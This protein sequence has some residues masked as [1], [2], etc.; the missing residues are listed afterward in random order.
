MMRNFDVYKLGIALIKDNI[1]LVD[2]T[3]DQDI[4]NYLQNL[5]GNCFTF[6]RNFV[7]GN[8]AN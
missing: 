8:T 4:R 6:L 1:D 7:E 2:Q 3:S 5:F